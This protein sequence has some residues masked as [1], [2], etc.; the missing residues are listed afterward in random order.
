[1]SSKRNIGLF[2]ALAFMWGTS[3]MAIKA[4]LAYLPPILFAS[5]RYDIA[6]LLLL[7]YAVF[8]G[9]QW[10]PS[11]R[12][13]WGYIGVNG[14]LLI[15]AH[16]ALMFT[17]QQYVTSAIGAV[18][19]SLMPILTPVFAWLLLSDERLSATGALGT[20]VGLAGVVIIAQPDPNN[21]G[22]KFYG[23]VL[24]FLSAASF[25]FGSVLTQRMP[26][27]LPLVPMQAWIMLSGSAMLHAVSLMLGESFASVQWT[28][29]SVSALLYLAV[30][31]GAAGFLIYFDL[32]ERLGPV[33]IS[34]V[35]YAVPIFASLTGWVVLGEQITPTT[36]TGFLA[37]ALG[38]TLVK[39]RRL[40]REFGILRG[41]VSTAKTSRSV[42]NDGS[43]SAV[44]K[45][46][47]D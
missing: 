35:N 6:G 19:L 46:D 34:L 14:A 31:A 10:R 1:M 9:D 2:V 4:G 11:S 3:F 22:T 42:R 5:F 28:V 40:R 25:S 47:A 33:E 38:F 23:V 8:A 45:Q 27:T 16:F 44:D 29:T 43:L 13:E 26:A 7:G 18:V 32:L 30:I 36:V 39:Q 37:I 15:G 24:L 12:R 17:G 20:L 41:K 21:L